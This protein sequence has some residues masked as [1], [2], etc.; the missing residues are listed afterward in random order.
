MFRITTIASSICILALA[1]LHDVLGG[2]I[3]GTNKDGSKWFSNELLS[4]GGD[5]SD[6]LLLGFSSFI[7]TLVFYIV[8]N[9]DAPYVY[10]INLLFVYLILFLVN[11]DVSIIGS[12]EHGD[13]VLLLL[14]LLIH[15]P[16]VYHL[17]RHLK[18]TLNSAV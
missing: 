1:Y 18:R 7:V 14:I 13:Y 4:S 5:D 9:T 16:L 3:I 12:I 17:T 2:L 8:K 10:Y 15:I 6:I 11:M